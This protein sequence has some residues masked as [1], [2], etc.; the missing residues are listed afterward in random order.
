MHPPSAR[1]EGERPSTHMLTTT[2]NL[3]VEWMGP[4]NV[5][6]TSTVDEQRERMCVSV[7]VKVSGCECGG[8]ERGEKEQDA[9]PSSDVFVKVCL[10]VIRACCLSV[11]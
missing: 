11:S 1:R 9:Q 7:H 10:F 6:W 2:S 4:A 5:T 3:F 8:G